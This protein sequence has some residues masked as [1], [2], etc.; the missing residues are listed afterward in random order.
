M[1]NILIPLSGKSTFNVSKLNAFPRIL[2]EVDG[3]L[4]IERAAEPFLKLLGDKKIIVAVPQKESEEYQLNK[5]AALLGESIRTCAINGDTQGAAC[6]ALLAI[7]SIELDKP[8]I[9]SSFEQVLDFDINPYIQEFIDDGVD[10]GVFTFE[11]IHPKWSYVK[12]DPNGYVTQA[13]EKMPISKNAIA[14]TY[15]FKTAQLF[16]DAAKSMIR[17]GV[18]TNDSFFISPTL[19]EVILK[20]GVVKA[21]EINRERYF[22]INDEHALEAFESKVVEDKEHQK[23]EIKKRTLAYIA[24]FSSKNIDKVASFFDSGFHLTDP[25]VSIKGKDQVVKYINDLFVS[26]DSLSFVGKNIFVTDELASIIEFE[27]TLGDTLLVGTDVI[28]WNEH[29]EMTIMNAYLYEKNNG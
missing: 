11:S 8:L 13:A 23:L 10:A 26:Q 16:M 4:L 17:K 7:E 19:N 29:R 15:Y 18:K 25:S 27:L 1:L 2:T 3:R 21:I 24:A 5:V 12:T 20:E 28:Q 22:H 14:G 6:S 9:I